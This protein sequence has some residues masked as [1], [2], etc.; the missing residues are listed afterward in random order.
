MHELFLQ[1][2]VIYIE[3][4]LRNLSVVYPSTNFRQRDL[5]LTG[6]VLRAE[7]QVKEHSHVSGYGA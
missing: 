2:Y 1:I 7:K 3:D 4:G 6:L 5:K